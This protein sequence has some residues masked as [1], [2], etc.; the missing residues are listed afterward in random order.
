MALGFV[1]IRSTTTAERRLEHRLK[2]ELC[3]NLTINH[4]CFSALYGGL[5]RGE[6]RA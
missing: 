1:G 6:F 3:F 5:V 4:R 2:P